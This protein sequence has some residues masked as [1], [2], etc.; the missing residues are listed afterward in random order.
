MPFK[1][2]IRS[3]RWTALVF[4]VAVLWPASELVA[5]EFTHGDY[6]VSVN[7][8]EQSVLSDSDYQIVV[9]SND[10]VLS[11]L[12][13]RSAGSLDQ[14]FVSDLNRDGGFEVVVTFLPAD[15]GAAD[16]HIYS[17]RNN[18]LEAQAVMTSEDG[19]Q[20]GTAVTGAFAIDNGLL[21]RND[22]AAGKRVVYTF[23]DGTWVS[24]SGQ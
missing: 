23:K 17:W 2:I 1:N 4:S 6:Q 9:S 10:L 12:S 7:L 20:A 16:L 3:S 18:L 22:A 24:A 14:A 5:A 11:R 13:A 21:V 15:Q 19:H 8:S